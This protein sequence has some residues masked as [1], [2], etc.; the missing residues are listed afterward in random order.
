MAGQVQPQRFPF[1][2]QHHLL[3][4]AWHVGVGLLHLLRRFRQNAKHVHL[5]DRFG[6]RMLIG[7]F[8]RVAQ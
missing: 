6:F 5:A 3:L 8:Q 1:T 2:I 7:R 4:P